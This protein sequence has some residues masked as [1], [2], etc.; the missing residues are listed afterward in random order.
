M[1]ENEQRLLDS[2]N[3]NALSLSDT[4]IAQ[5]CHLFSLTLSSVDVGIEQR[6]RGHISN[7][8]VARISCLYAAPLD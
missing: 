5:E 8:I 4:N 6:S 7:S 3:N 1:D 2:W